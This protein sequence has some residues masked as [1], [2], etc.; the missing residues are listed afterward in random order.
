MSLNTLHFLVAMYFIPNFVPKM[1]E[2]VPKR[3]KNPPFW[4]TSTGFGKTP[5]VAKHFLT[6][7]FP[8]LLIF[9]TFAVKIKCRARCKRRQCAVRGFVRRGT[10]EQVNRRTPRKCQRGRA[11]ARRKSI[12]RHRASASEARRVRRQFTAHRGVSIRTNKKRRINI[13]TITNW[14]SF[15]FRT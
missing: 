6:F 13:W 14:R 15:F 4:N 3:N 8:N 10:R 7:Y 12:A 2:S 5:P 9:N 11:Q 1:P